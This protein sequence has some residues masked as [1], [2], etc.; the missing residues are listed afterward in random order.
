M[1]SK[2]SLETLLDLVEIKLS[3]IEVYDRDDDRERRRLEACRD[4]L[5]ALRATPMSEPAVA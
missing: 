3:C 1:L 4:E 2:K 5:I